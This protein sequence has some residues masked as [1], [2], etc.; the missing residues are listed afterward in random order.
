MPDDTTWAAGRLR[1]GDDTL[2]ARFCAQVQTRPVCYTPD[3]MH[4]PRSAPKLWEIAL[5]LLNRDVLAILRD[6]IAS[7]DDLLRFLLGLHRQGIYE[8]LDHDTK[9][10]LCDAKGQLAQ[11]TR[12]QTVRFLQDHLVA[13][14]DYAWGDGQTLAEYTC[15]PGLPV[16]VYDDGAKKTILISLRETKGRGDVLRFCIQRKI[17][18]GFGKRQEWWE[19]EIYHRT[20]RLRVVILFPKGRSCRRA[21]VVQ[22]SNGRTTT[23]GEEHF[24]FHQDGRQRLA[25][26]VKRPKLHDRYTIKWL[27]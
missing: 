11:V 14:T 16:D 20:R 27:W 8:V 26:E 2:S 13:F 9:L 23:L 25:W 21:V 3:S 22:R 17:V 6:V 4:K 1:R 12:R 24:C 10:E 19:T 15:R 18:A 5:A 7:G